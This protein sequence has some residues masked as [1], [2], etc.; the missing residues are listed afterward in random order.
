[1]FPPV[2][3]YSDRREFIYVYQPAR[4]GYPDIMIFELLLIVINSAQVNIQGKI[5]EGETQNHFSLKL[6]ILNV[7]YRLMWTPT[8]VIDSLFL[9]SNAG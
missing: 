2:S 9:T 1:L 6:L 7:N 8:K 5:S 4:L 3:R